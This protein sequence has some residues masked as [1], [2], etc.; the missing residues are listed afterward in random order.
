MRRRRRKEGNIINTESAG[1]TFSR[2]IGSTNY[3]VR[4]HF[5]PD[6]SDT[7]EDRILHLIH[8]E[9]VTNP[10]AYDILTEPQMSRQSERSA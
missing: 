9:I 1:F 2:R 4:V 10:E 5:D 3:K 7:M 6:A 8:N